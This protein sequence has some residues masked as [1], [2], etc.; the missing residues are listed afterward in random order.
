MSHQRRTETMDIVEEEDMPAFNL[1]DA[2]TS[3]SDNPQAQFDEKRL[4]Q[5]WCRLIRL[6]IPTEFRKICPPSNWSSYN[7][8]LRKATPQNHSRLLVQLILKCT[9]PLIRQRDLVMD[10]TILRCPHRATTQD[11]AQDTIY[12]ANVSKTVRNQIKM[13]RWIF[14]WVA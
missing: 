8:N 4:R 2:P 9:T 14:W 10:M 7:R 13:C 11:A 3:N 12:H 5:L 1:F 6:L